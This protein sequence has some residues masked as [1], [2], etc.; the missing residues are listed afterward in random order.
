[1]NTAIL[2]KRLVATYLKMPA[3]AI[4]FVALTGCMVPQQRVV[5]NETPPPPV[6]PNFVTQYFPS[7]LYKVAT[8]D[9]LE[10]LFLTSPTE[11]NTPYKIGIR[12]SLDVEFIYQPEL[13]RTVRVR[14]DG[15]ISIPRKDDVQVAGLTP[16]EAKRMLKKTYSDLLKDPEIA[17]TV[18][19][20]NA[21]LDEIQRTITTGQNGQARLVTVRPDGFI[22]LPFLQDIRV[23]NRTVPEIAQQVN[24]MYSGVIPNMAV[25]AMLREIVGE[26][27]F[28]D[29]EVGRPGVFS[30]K[31][32]ISVQQAIALAGGTK[33]TAEPRTVLIVSKG[34]DGR[35]LTRTTDLT[36]MSSAT[37]FTL[38]RN[39][40]VFVPKSAIARADVWVDQ[41]IRRVLLFTGW[42]LGLS[43]DLGR[44]V[45]TTR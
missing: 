28:V 41:N 11:S 4:V 3:V 29:G 17:V 19:E 43:S 9:I 10:F 18:R 21:K 5:F 37:D 39:D 7:D 12:D 33:E 22:S 2:L 23:E 32:P 13:N 40:L 45:T 26:V 34:P 14:P 15:K 35:F 20:F 44:T 38:R 24:K 36:R 31:G 27:I 42:S 6:G 8:G 30:T 16:D 1:M 25:T